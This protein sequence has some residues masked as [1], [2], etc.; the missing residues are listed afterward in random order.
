MSAE[1]PI[2][3][4]A[5]AGGDLSLSG[6]WSAELD[7]IEKNRLLGAIAEEP[8]LAED[9]QG[10]LK[11][12]PARNRRRLVE[13]F[14]RRLARHRH[15]RDAVLPALDDLLKELTMEAAERHLSSISASS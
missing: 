15:S 8:D 1:E 4:F 2:H 11:E 6:T 12:L 7:E 10:L 5:S 9:L 3:P 13:H 14:A